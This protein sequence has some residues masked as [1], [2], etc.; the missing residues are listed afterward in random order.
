MKKEKITSILLATAIVTSQV[1]MPVLANTVDLEV[2]TSNDILREDNDVL[3]NEEEIKVKELKKENEK[4]RLKIDKYE[5]FSNMNSIGLNRGNYHGRKSL[6]FILPANTE[7]KIR[8]VNTSLNMDLNLDLLND[9]SHKEKSL[10][11]PKNGEWITV[12]SDSLSVPFIRKVSSKQVPE[13]E[14]ILNGKVNKLPQYNQNGNEAEFFKEWDSL[15]SEF[16]FIENNRVQMLIPKKDKNY[17]KKMDDFSSID[18]LFEFYNGMFDTYDRL[19]GLEKNASNP[20][21][22]NVDTQYF[23]KA[24]KHG[25]G[26]AYYG[27]DHTAQ[28][29]D[30]MSAYLKKGWLPLHEVGHGYEYNIK[31]KEIYLVDV[32]NNILAHTYERT[33]LNGD[34]GWLFNGNRNNRDLSMKNIRKNG[35]YKDADYGD[36]LG[37]FVYLLEFIGEKKFSE[38]NRLYREKYATGEIVNKS[39]T[40]IFNELLS[41]ITGYNFREYFSSYK[42]FDNNNI[43]EDEKYS[44]YKNVF[45]LGD[46]ITDSDTVNKIKNEY[47]LKSIYSIIST[48]DM[49]KSN[50]KINKGSLNVTLPK[51]YVNSNYLIQLKD[52]ENIIKE[53]KIENSSSINLTD[54]IPGRYT[55]AIIN[56]NNNFNSYNS[57]KTVDIKSGKNNISIPSLND[58]STVQNVLD[59]KI[60]FKGLGDAV[61]A[62][63]DVNLSENIIK[64]KTNS[65][66]PH[67]YYSSEYAKIEILDQSDKVV[68]SKSYIGNKNE[69]YSEEKIVIRPGFKVN[70]YHD[71]AGTRLSIS[72]YEKQK[73]NYSLTKQNSFTITDLGLDNNTLNLNTN[74]ERMVELFANNLKEELG[75]K[76][77]NYS[78]Y[79]NHRVL[80]N[81]MI[82]RLP[83][84]SKEK[85]IERYKDMIVDKNNDLVNIPDSNLKVA[86][87]EKLGQAKDASIYQKQLENLKGDLNLSDKGIKNLKGLEHC[88][89]V[90]SI[91]VSNNEISDISFLEKFTE[92]IV[93]IP[94]E[95]NSLNFINFSNNKIKDLT[96]FAVG[97]LNY[98]KGILGYSK[99]GYKN[100]DVVYKKT[101]ATDTTYLF[102]FSHNEISDIN[103]FN[104]EE[105]VN[106]GAVING[107]NLSNNQIKDISPLSAFELSDSNLSNNQ[108]SDVSPLNNPN[109]YNIKVQN[110]IIKG[111]KL[112]A[113]ETTVKVRNNLK[114]VNGMAVEPSNSSNYDYNKETN[115]IIF[116]NINS[117]GEREYNFSATYPTGYEPIEFSGKVVHEI[118]KIQ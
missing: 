61:F 47:N 98:G 31:N 77:F 92:N 52:G 99:T 18:R 68:F 14:F 111:E 19:L 32:F 1:A 73:L 106:M 37:V 64:L 10:T 25:A 108:I 57:V 20:L 94:L 3:N 74:L 101:K 26:A 56:K 112:S 38:F 21:H 16:A 50:V 29:S 6:G 87:N 36:K 104:M 2:Q 7:L 89:R 90:S 65:G 40:T 75:D 69:S 116:K 113:K 53:A 82:N 109:N 96:P 4:Y 102:D 22:N 86:L 39:A 13:V 71:E 91:D 115:E 30:S 70:I 8:Q 72:D 117:S 49:L 59:Q 35:S 83:S 34:E 43:I 97:I 66:E 76:I 41:E 54:I 58:S 9:D 110:Q 23:I 48:E 88:I 17:L 79:Q 12:S 45:I 81:N 5:D 85:F 51:D 33:Y 84:E 95:E 78:F 27:W 11:I 107:V 62:E 44:K 118:E 105:L 100:N 28:N 93:K 60:T 80:L 42:L 114:N 15:D 46:I 103:C 55:L 24:N 63:L 67:S